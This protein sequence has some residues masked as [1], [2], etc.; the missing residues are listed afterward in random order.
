MKNLKKYLVNA[1][2]E[3]FAGVPDSCLS[4]FISELSE[5]KSLMHVRATSE[6]EA[7][8]ISAGYAI[9]SSKP[10]VV[11][12]Q[13]SGLGN[14]INPLS[15]LCNTEMFGVPIVLVIGW[16]GQPDTDDVVE[17][18][19]MG[20]IT[21]EL[22]K[23]LDIDVYILDSSGIDEAKVSAVYKQC[24]E[25]QKPVA[26]LVA[27]TKSH[28]VKVQKIPKLEEI[29]R[30]KAV[31]SVV[32]QFKMNALFVASTGLIAREIAEIVEF[33]VRTLFVVGSMGCA[34]AIA[35]GVT[36]VTESTVVVLDGDGAALMHMGNMATIGHDSPNN[37]IHVILDNG[38]YE[39]TGGQY[40]ITNGIDL[41]KV[42]EACNYRTVINVEKNSQ[43]IS[44]CNHAAVCQ[45]PV[46]IRIKISSSNETPERIKISPQENKVQFRV[47]I[48]DQ[49]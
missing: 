1:G 16:R 15:S 28:A 4:E 8:S 40:S 33:N 31:E 44:A 18:K 6:S 13:N 25:S 43:L 30:K 27:N 41:G 46:L 21:L 7:I 23:L 12:M 17:H 2:I 3:S 36:M 5:D 20:R 22:L 14:A 32:S 24:M 26:L 39:S 45:K 38:C 37:L 19:L 35:Y 47:A 9:A 48:A 11:Y 49:I 42:A 29:D 34:S 10:A